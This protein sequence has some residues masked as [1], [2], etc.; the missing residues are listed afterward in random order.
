MFVLVSM[1]Q[2][3]Q[4]R[5]QSLNDVLAS[6]D[7]CVVGVFAT[8][9]LAVQN[10]SVYAG[11]SHAGKV[12]LIYE[13]VPVGNK[14]KRVKIYEG[15]FPLCAPKMSDDKQPSLA[16]LNGQTKIMNKRIQKL[17]EKLEAKGA[18]CNRL[19]IENSEMAVSND[20]TK[21]VNKHTQ[22]LEE[23]LEAKGAECNRLKDENTEMRA[24]INRMKILI[25]A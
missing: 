9:E 13:M 5:G 10:I 6:M 15:S 19:K 24:L 2:K 23:K 25:Q 21:I 8:K 1:P 3:M 11:S 12:A 14:Q 20:F 4:W 22:R 18:E 16:Y 17:E 7:E